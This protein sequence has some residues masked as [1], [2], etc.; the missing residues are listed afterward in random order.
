MKKI[1]KI[2]MRVFFG[3]EIVLFAYVY[4]FGSHGMRALMNI[5]QE[6]VQLATDISGLQAEVRCLE[7]TIAQWDAHPF[8]KE[9]I[10]REQLQM[11]GKNEEI[12]Y[13]S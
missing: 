3:T 7:K 4:L 2:C 1:K 9:K 6:K 5:E 11:A 12:Y 10:A 13:V 8:Y